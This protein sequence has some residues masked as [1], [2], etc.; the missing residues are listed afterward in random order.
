MQTYTHFYTVGSHGLGLD[1]FALGGL[2][3]DELDSLE[4]RDTD[5]SVVLPYG[6]TPAQ[7]D[8]DRRLFVRCSR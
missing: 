8:A 5:P 3:D 7:A 4:E 2:S 6:I 1:F